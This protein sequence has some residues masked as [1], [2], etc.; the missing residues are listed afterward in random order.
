MRT[1][2][3]IFDILLDGTK[4][5]IEGLEGCGASYRYSQGCGSFSVALGA[6]EIRAHKLLDPPACVPILGPEHTL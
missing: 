3:D 4:A 6:D 2:E 5:Q 1:L